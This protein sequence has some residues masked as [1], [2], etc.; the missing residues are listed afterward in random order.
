MAI[1]VHGAT[2]IDNSKHITVSGAQ[3][4]GTLLLPEAGLLQVSKDNGSVGQFG[5]SDT[6]LITIG[7]SSNSK[8]I[9]LRSSGFAD[10]KQVN[11]NQIL[12]VG[13]DNVQ[14]NP[15]GSSTFAGT[16]AVNE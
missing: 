10:F 2:V 11:V 1:K 4:D 12:K 8:N 14:I 16:V 6:E 3:V 5:A 7:N 9:I 15:D 13:G